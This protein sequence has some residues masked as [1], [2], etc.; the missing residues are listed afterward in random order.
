M[1]QLRQVFHW[2]ENI[3]YDNTD[4]I[5]TQNK[6]NSVQRTSLVCSV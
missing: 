5:L 6:G 2:P 1:E 3:H 4:T